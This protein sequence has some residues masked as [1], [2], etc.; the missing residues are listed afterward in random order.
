VDDRIPESAPARPLAATAALVVLAGGAGALAL[1]R[2]AAGLPLERLWSGEWWRLPAGALAEPRASYLL[3]GLLALA[4]AARP[5]EARR[6][7][8][9]VVAAFAAAALGGFATGLA[10]AGRAAGGIAAGAA[11]V[12]AALAAASPEDR[13]AALFFGGLAAALAGIERALAGAAVG[14]LAGLAV[15]LGA[16]RRL[17]LVAAAAIALAPAALALRPR[18]AESPSLAQARDAVRAGDL[19]RAAPALERILA[20]FPAPALDPALFEDA[21]DLA[22]EGGDAPLAARWYRL[23]G[24][25]GG[26]FAPWH[27]LGMI[28]LE[29]GGADPRP[30]ERALAAEAPPGLD[31]DLYT[32]GVAWLAAGRRDLALAA[33]REAGRG[34]LGEPEG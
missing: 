23:A 17:A 24:E 26:G 7:R 14:A 6:G 11:G 19:G 10:L 30:F 20:L 15:E 13:R 31:R 12:A 16:R 4:G 1:A 8:A 3:L 9:A 18:W 27:R 29:G 22:R 25:A 28:A 2:G 32:R 33:L 21:A 34:A 5:Y